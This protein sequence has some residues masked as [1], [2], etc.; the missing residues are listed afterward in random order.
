[1]ENKY[2]KKNIKV[3]KYK[4]FKFKVLSDFYYLFNI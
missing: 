3:N 1:M 4:N 2:N